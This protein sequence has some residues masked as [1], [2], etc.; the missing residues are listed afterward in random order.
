MGGG[1]I[2]N[3][4]TDVVE[5]FDIALKCSEQRAIGSMAV[6]KVEILDEIS[7]DINIEEGRGGERKREEA[8]GRERK[9]E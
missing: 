4:P 9:R 6:V 8:R 7:R 3:Y 5:M 2:G 1:C